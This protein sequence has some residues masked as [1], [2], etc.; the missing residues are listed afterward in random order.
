LEKSRYKPFGR[1]W[2]RYG[3]EIARVFLQSGAKTEIA[4]LRAFNVVFS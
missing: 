3:R 1:F 2:R 4:A